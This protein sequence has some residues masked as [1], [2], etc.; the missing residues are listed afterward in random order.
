MYFVLAV[1]RRL[2]HLGRERM[3]R[4]GEEGP[5]QP[6]AAGPALTIG[7]ITHMLRSAK[8]SAAKTKGL[9][10]WWHSWNTLRTRGWLPVLLW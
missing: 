5:G 8:V 4:Q 1:M 7:S 10:V 3:D 2:T 6:R 9:Y